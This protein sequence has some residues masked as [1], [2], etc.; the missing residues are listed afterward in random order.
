VNYVR[1][2]TPDGRKWEESQF[3]NHGFDPF[4]SWRVGGPADPGET[5]ILTTLFGEGDRE[6]SV[7][8]HGGNIRCLTGTYRIVIGH[9]DS[10][11]WT[12]SLA[13]GW[14]VNLPEDEL[15]AFVDETFTLG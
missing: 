5:V 3:S 14:I 4:P 7:L 2:Y 9:T 13:G 11:G 6:L 10:I 1:L 15:E 8:I 12:K